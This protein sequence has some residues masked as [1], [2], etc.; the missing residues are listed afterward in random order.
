MSESTRICEQCGTELPGQALACPSCRRLV[1]SGR[2]KEL[3]RE[4]EGAKQDGD[5]DT[6]I[7]LWREALELLPPQTSQAKEIG[8]RIAELSKQAKVRTPVPKSLLAFGALGL[9]LWKFK[10][11]IV[12]VLSKGK[13]ILLGL[14]KLGTLKSMGVFVAAL[15]TSMGWELALGLVLSIYIHEMGHVASLVSHGI[16]AEAPMF[17]PGLGAF[18]RLKQR[19]AN[20]KEDATIGL[21]GP[22]WGLAAVL[23]CGLFFFTTGHQVWGTLTVFGALLNLFNLI[24][25]WQ[26]DGARGCRPLNRGQR[27]GLLICGCL[28]YGATAQPV[29][30]LFALLMLWKCVTTVEQEDGDWATFTLFVFLLVTLSFLSAWPIA[31]LSTL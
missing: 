23:V 16:K 11:L 26:L 14:T 17:V 28:L 22:V 9:F 10:F 20:P 4:A 5:P 24:P 8:T 25:V 7:Q 12:A 6:A 3:A 31:G 30:I 15:S 19:P 29:L 18:V 1:H 2:L 21:A 13:L 27:V